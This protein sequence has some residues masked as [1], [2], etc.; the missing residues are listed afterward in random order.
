MHLQCQNDFCN[1]CCSSSVSVKTSDEV[2][3]EA[4]HEMLKNIPSVVEDEEAI[5]NPPQL[6]S[7]AQ[8]PKRLFTFQSLMR[9]DPSTQAN[10]SASGDIELPSK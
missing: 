4:A 10:T 8:A 1:P 2:V 5:L 3:I 9:A 7:G 6:M